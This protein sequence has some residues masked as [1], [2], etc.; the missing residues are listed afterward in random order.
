MLVRVDD[1]L[2]MRLDEKFAGKPCV[3]DK[4]CEYFDEIVTKGIE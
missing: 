3:V 2:I 1:T 4:G